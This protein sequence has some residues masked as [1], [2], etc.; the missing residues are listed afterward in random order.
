MVDSDAAPMS[1]SQLLCPRS[2]VPSVHKPGPP[3]RQQ[4][5]HRRTDPQTRVHDTLRFFQKDS[6]QSR[7]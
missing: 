3:K 4:V 7:G 2:A 6:S 5:L 1:A